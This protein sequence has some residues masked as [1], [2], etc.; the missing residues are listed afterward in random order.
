MVI[1][2]HDYYQHASRSYIGTTLC[3]RNYYVFAYVFI[4]G[5]SVLLLLLFLPYLLYMG[6][7][8]KVRVETGNEATL[9]QFMKLPVHC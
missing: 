6:K 8:K 3:T 2:D 1:T 5:L 9:V 7:R 4:H